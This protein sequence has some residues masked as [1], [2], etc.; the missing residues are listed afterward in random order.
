MGVSLTIIDKNFKLSN[1]ESM[2][3]NTIIQVKPYE[4][5]DD[6]A[7]IDLCFSNMFH[8]QSVTSKM[9][10]EGALIKY[11]PAKIGLTLSLAYAFL[12]GLS[13]MND[14]PWTASCIV[15]A[16]LLAT[17][18]LIL[19][20]A[21]LPAIMQKKLSDFHKNKLPKEFADIQ[22]SF[23]GAGRCFWMATLSSDPQSSSEKIVGSVLVEP[24]NAKRDYMEVLQYSDIKQEVAELRRMSVDTLIRRR[25]IGQKLVSEVKNFCLKNGYKSIVLTTLA[26]NKVAQE[27]YKKAGFEFLHKICNPNFKIPFTLAVLV[28]KL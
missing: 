20:G 3:S 28:M 27:F 14:L 7:L 10:I 6:Q 26:S 24:Y 11:G 16:I 9:L 2:S 23:M 22:G 5:L 1:P 25:G 4:K 21:V 17:C 18:L 19:Y 15:A 8:T 12:V 13:K